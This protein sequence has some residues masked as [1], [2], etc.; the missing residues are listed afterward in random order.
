[1]CVCF[2][3]HKTWKTS[4]NSVKIEKKQSSLQI[5]IENNGWEIERLI[6]L[7]GNQNTTELLLIRISVLLL[8]GRQS[9]FLLKIRLSDY[10]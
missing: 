10:G 2:Q 7:K 3:I 9:G 1:M 6:K 4:S 8:T 5:I